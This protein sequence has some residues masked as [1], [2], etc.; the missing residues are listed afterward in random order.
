M[1]SACIMLATATASPQSSATSLQPKDQ[2]SLIMHDGQ[3]SRH[4]M[5]ATAQPFWSD[6][7]GRKSLGSTPPPHATQ[8]ITTTQPLDDDVA[9]YAGVVARMEARIGNASCVGG[10]CADGP[11]Y[12]SSAG[13]CA[14]LV[15]F[16]AFPN[17]GSTWLG[18]LF[19]TATGIARESNATY[20]EGGATTPYGSQVEAHGSSARADVRPA[21]GSEPRP[22]K[23]HNALAWPRY[24]RI[25]ALIRDPLDNVESTF[26]F[27]QTSYP[28]KLEGWTEDAYDMA[29][30]A[31]VAS[32]WCHA[33]TSTVPVLLATY[34]QLLAQPTATLRRV[35]EFTGYNVTDA[36]LERALA[37]YPADP[38]TP[39]DLEASYPDATL[40][41]ALLSELEEASVSDACGVFSSP[42]AS[43]VGA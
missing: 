7:L 43:T 10:A 37:A 30:A 15:G 14:P 34:E 5:A 40:R 36:D 2:R 17:A 42:W 18:L 28:D 8:A 41:A 13:S 27:T 16:L 38:H 4:A 24:S 23:E 26:G 9:R 39:F 20:W 22:I 1:T 11:C 21:E 25:V 6:N 19:E 29:A 32:W 31:D 12:A 3:L 35:I 33:A